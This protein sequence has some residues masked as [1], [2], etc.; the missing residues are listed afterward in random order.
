MLRMP[1]Q[2]CDSL[3]DEESM[4][5]CDWCQQGC[6]MGCHDP[7]LTEFPAD[8]EDYFCPR[9]TK[10]GVK[11]EAARQL[12][13][14]MHKQQRAAGITEDD[15]TDLLAAQLEGKD[16][17]I[18]E[19][20]TATPQPADAAAAADDGS[21]AVAA[22][23]S[24][25]AAAAVAAAGEEAGPSTSKPAAAQSQVSVALFVCCSCLLVPSLLAYKDWSAETIL[26]QLARL[27]HSCLCAAVWHVYQFTSQCTVTALRCVVPPRLQI[28]EDT[29]NSSNLAG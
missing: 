11:H 26:V 27:I 14:D 23:P 3:E 28:Y 25:R 5:I 19:D 18:L 16:D 22:Q 10:V 13:T 4:L 1:V 7:P 6:H 17:G 29:S 20:E 24:S 2:I 8:D 21:T 15:M 12:C 9:H